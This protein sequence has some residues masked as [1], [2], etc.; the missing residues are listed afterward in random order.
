MDRWADGWAGSLVCECMGVQVG[1]QTDG[2]PNGQTDWRVNR[3][4][5]RE[6]HRQKD[7]WKEGR[8]DGQTDRETYVLMDWWTDRLICGWKEGKME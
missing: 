3:W 1:R 7:R 5:D 4:A 2:F 8:T 6:T